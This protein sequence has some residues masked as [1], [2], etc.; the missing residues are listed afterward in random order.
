MPRLVSWILLATPRRAPGA[1]LN[2]CFTITTVATPVALELVVMPPEVWGGFVCW[3]FEIKN[4]ESPLKEKRPALGG[5]IAVPPLRPD[6][7]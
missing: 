4:K 7:K 1:E 6:M 2:Y 5:A 3:N